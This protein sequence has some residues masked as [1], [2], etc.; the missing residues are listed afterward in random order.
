MK[1]FSNIDVEEYS[2]PESYDENEIDWE[3]LS[4]LGESI[5]DDALSALWSESSNYERDFA[6]AKIGDADND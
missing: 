4:R 6:S 2:V 3:R 1:D 5:S